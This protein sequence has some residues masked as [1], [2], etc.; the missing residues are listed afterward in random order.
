MKNFITF[1][2]EDAPEPVNPLTNASTMFNNYNDALNMAQ[3]ISTNNP[4]INDR[5][6]ILQYKY[7]K[8]KGTKPFVVVHN[9]QLISQEP[10]WVDKGYNIKGWVSSVDGIVSKTQDGKFVKGQQQ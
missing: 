10:N 8:E 6:Y 5:A 3:S 9:K 4:G 1:L 7:Y 2:K